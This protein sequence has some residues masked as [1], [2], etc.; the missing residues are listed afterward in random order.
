MLLSV[1][2]YG[3]R[4]SLVHVRNKTA[5]TFCLVVTAERTTVLSQK[6]PQHNEMPVFKNLRLISRGWAPRR[7]GRLSIVTWLG[8]V[9]SLLVLSSDMAP[10]LFWIS[11]ETDHRHGWV[12]TRLISRWVEETQSHLQL[13][14]G[15]CFHPLCAHSSGL[16]PV[17]CECIYRAA[18]HSLT[19]Q[20]KCVR[21]SC[22][23]V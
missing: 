2:I 7:T 22:E 8:L 21:E 17:V 10:P 9:V 16:V 19:S 11:A 1:G 5:A 14:C 20:F 4:L 6:A 12:N 15:Y 23:L 3:W 18:L 13:I